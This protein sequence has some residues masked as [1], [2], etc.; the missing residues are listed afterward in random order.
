MISQD[1][2]FY[3]RDVSKEDSPRDSTLA[4]IVAWTVFI[5]L[6]FFAVIAVVLLQIRRHNE[7]VE[8]DQHASTLLAANGYPMAEVNIHDGGFAEVPVGECKDVSIVVEN[9]QVLVYHKDNLHSPPVAIGNGYDALVESAPSFG[10]GDCIA[11][12]S[13]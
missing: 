10:Y 4:T 5:G 3:Q 13:P 8:L 12:E 1:T 9:E 11:G 2:H 6:V 7:S